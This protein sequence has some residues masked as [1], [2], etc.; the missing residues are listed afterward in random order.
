MIDRYASVY[1]NN[2]AMGCGVQYTTP[3]AV[4]EPLP[5]YDGEAGIC[6]TADCMVD[7]RTEL[8]DELCPGMDGVSD[9]ELMF[10]AFK[11]WRDD[12]PKHVRGAYSYAAYDIKNNRL[13]VGADHVF[14]R[15]IYYSRIG[16][17]VYFS[18]LIE[19][20]L[21]GI[22][23]KPEINE[24]WITLFLSITS[25]ATLSNPVDTPYKNISRVQASHYVV[26]GKDGNKPVEYWSPKN[27]KPLRLK[28]DDEY[29]ERF[30][31][32]MEQAAAEALRTPG[33]VGILLSSGL[34]SSSVAAFAEPILAQ[35]GK[36]L[37]SYTYVPIEAYESSFNKKY[38]NTDERSGV[39]MVCGMYPGIIPKFLDVPEQNAISSI[40]RILPSLE[41]PYKSHTNLAWIDA[42]AGI[43]QSDGCK[44]MLTGQLGNATISAG[45][46]FT[47]IL[48][49]IMH[50]RVIDAIT[51]A[52]RYSV[53]R[54]VSRKWTV[55]HVLHELTPGFARR[56]GVKDHW[57]VSYINRDFARGIGVTDK[58]SRT[59]RN[60][61]LFK[62]YTF[63]RER[64]LVFNPTAMAQVGEAETK[65][66]LKHGMIA[67]DITRDISILE[68]CLSAPIEC[69]VGPDGQTR[70]LIRNYLSDKLP[71]ALIDE[72]TPKGRQ[73]GDA[74]DRLALRW[75]SFYAELTRGCAVPQ[76]QKYIDIDLVAAALKKFETLPDPGS[77]KEFV[78]LCAVYLIGIF[79]EIAESKYNKQDK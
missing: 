51:A 49:R 41:V 55:R 1:K 66:Y 72:R 45:N 56:R 16:D 19:P 13:I 4:R 79:L 2:V 23:E 32:L 48:S 10:L 14:N 57:G 29:R 65:L 63:E 77:E 58:D 5:I 60:M 12:I 33:E 11:K 40:G 78:R 9:G 69:F 68:F 53:K 54:G 67:R 28:R 27:V 46:I 31:S 38:I 47:Y 35:N 61:G 44:I 24:E 76:L 26:F 36:R 71:A 21:K 39:E 50:G 15:S 8:I 6:F 64:S 62:L 22:G 18:T 59:E 43:A 7:N 25:L 37:Y 34:D 75:D 52:N 30:R 73:S 70:R 3:E 42:F 20:I 74:L 17:R